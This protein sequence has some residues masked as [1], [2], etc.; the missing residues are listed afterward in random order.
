MRVFSTKIKILIPAIIILLGCFSCQTALKL[1]LRIKEPKQF[2]D[3]EEREEYYEP[4]MEKTPKYYS[5]LKIYTVSDT[6]ALMSFVRKYTSYPMIVIQ[7]KRTDSIYKLDCFEDIKWIVE[8]V[9]SNKLAYL[10][11]MLKYD[12]S[13]NPNQYDDIKK[14][15]KNNT[16]TW[17]ESY[18]STGTDNNKWDVYMASGTFMGKKLRRMS[19]PVTEIK[20]IGDFHIIDLSVNK[21]P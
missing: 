3:N 7:N 21:K 13:G 6:T 2:V 5:S 4:F 12:L 10:N 20:N 1:F 16:V 15:V 11:R 9:N 14:L 19:L 17:Y 18:D 8:H